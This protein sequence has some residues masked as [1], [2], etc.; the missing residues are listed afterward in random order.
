MHAP[1]YKRDMGADPIDK[2][3][4]AFAEH[5]R[6]GDTKQLLGGRDRSSRKRRLR[7]G[8]GAP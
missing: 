1:G 8:K 3:T 6:I 5:A 2:R 4:L 7:R